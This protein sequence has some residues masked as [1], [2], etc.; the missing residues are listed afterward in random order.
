MRIVLPVLSD[1]LKI[2]DTVELG[3]LFI[4]VMFILSITLNPRL[5][6]RPW[7]WYAA[8]SIFNLAQVSLFLFARH[9]LD[10]LNPLIRTF[11]FL[12]TYAY[13]ISLTVT[14][15]EYRQHNILNRGII[16]TTA[17]ILIGYSQPL[18]PDSVVSTVRYSY[19]LLYS[20]LLLYLYAKLGGKQYWS[21]GLFGFLYSANSMFLWLLGFLFGGTMTY[22][23]QLFETGFSL[24]STFGLGF[25]VAL[26]HIDLQARQREEY[27]V[28][29]EEANELRRKA[30]NV[31]ASNL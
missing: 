3:A 27:M 22:N 23:Y 30:I 16:I 15:F 13:T 14:V 2:L 21:V 25:A 5:T 18:W 31:A 17:I 24:I 26:M 10:G 6:S 20:L 12:C 8:T 28:Q 4:T 7:R 11:I 1:L 9:Y 29:V 19:A